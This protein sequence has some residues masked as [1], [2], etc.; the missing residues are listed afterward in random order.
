MQRRQFF[1][2]PFVALLSTITFGKSSG[3]TAESKLD[4]ITVLD[5]HLFFYD[6]DYRDERVIFRYSYGP[7]LGNVAREIDWNAQQKG[8]I[9]GCIDFDNSGLISQAQRYKVGDTMW[10]IPNPSERSYYMI[11]ITDKKD[12]LPSACYTI[13]THKHVI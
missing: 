4:M 2:T 5:K 1:L 7:K 10:D 9:I 6:R 11:C 12:I 3:K 8:D 13:K